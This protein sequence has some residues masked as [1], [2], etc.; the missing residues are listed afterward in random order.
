MPEENVE[1]VRKPLRVRERSRRTLDQRLAV[2]F[3]QLIDPYARLIGRLPPTSRVRQAVMWRG[4]R[5]GMEAFNRRDVDAA[6]VAGSAEFELHPPRKFV[7]VGF[8]PCYRGRAG[9][10]KYMSTWADVFSDLRVE[11]VELIDM[12]DRIVLLADLA[13]RGQSSGVPFTGTVAT[14]SWLKD[15]RATRVEVHLGHAD[16]LRAVGLEE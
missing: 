8:E 3:P 7:E 1:M 16:T 13:W 2:R 5:N 11:P 12:G 6:V 15:G 14:V 10:R 9:F 4:T